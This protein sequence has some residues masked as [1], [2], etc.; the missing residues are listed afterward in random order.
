VVDFEIWIFINGKNINT[1]AI[2]FV[3]T[4]IAEMNQI[5]DKIIVSITFES[6]Y[7]GLLCN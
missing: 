2:K 5:V 3:F 7:R 6:S 1:I 4:K